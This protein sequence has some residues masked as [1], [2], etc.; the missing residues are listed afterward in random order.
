ME[1]WVTAV[2]KCSCPSLAMVTPLPPRPNTAVTLLVSSAS[3]AASRSWCPGRTT[4]NR[5]NVFMN[6][7]W[8]YNVGVSRYIPPAGGSLQREVEHEGS[9]LTAL[10]PR[11]APESTSGK[12]WWKVHRATRFRDPIRQRPSPSNPHPRVQH[13]CRE[14][15]ERGQKQR[16]D[17]A[18]RREVTTTSGTGEIQSHRL[19]QESA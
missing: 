10:A 9:W 4:Q 19:A 17:P 5:D 16:G 18:Q 8:S 15:R 14:S 13:Q 7:R 6:N 12:R 1:S 3:A 11:A 2:T